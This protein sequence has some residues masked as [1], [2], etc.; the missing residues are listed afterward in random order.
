LN[1]CQRPVNPVAATVPPPWAEWWSQPTVTQFRQGRVIPG[2]PQ[3]RRTECPCRIRLMFRNEQLR[4]CHGPFRRH[5][6]DG[7]V[8][9]G[10]RQNMRRDII[11]LTPFRRTICWRNARGNGRYAWGRPRGTR[12]RTCQRGSLHTFYTGRGAS[13]RRLGFGRYAPYRQ[14]FSGSRRSRPVRE[15]GWSRVFVPGPGQR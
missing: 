1:V 14:P 11:P 2:K 12:R 10:H 7:R 8:K 4:R 9:T 3:G 6:R 13:S 5:G 15:G